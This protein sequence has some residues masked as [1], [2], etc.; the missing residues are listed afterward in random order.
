M[1]PPL[2]LYAFK[3]EKSLKIVYLRIR[4]SQNFAKF[5]LFFQFHQND[6]LVPKND[7]FAKDC[8]RSTEQLATE[9]VNNHARIFSEDQRSLAAAP[10][11]S[12]RIDREIR[13]RRRR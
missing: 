13:R 9:M 10:A 7:E 1:W 4:I 8:W 2:Y 11:W 5:R 12:L 3:F 6:L